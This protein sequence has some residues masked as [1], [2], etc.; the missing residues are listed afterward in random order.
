MLSFGTSLKFLRLSLGTLSVLMGVSVAVKQSNDASQGGAQE[1]ACH[2]LTSSARLDDAETHLRN[3]LSNDITVEDSE[4]SGRWAKDMHKQMSAA[5]CEVSLIGASEPFHLALQSLY[6]PLG[7]RRQL[8][9]KLGLGAKWADIASAPEE[10]NMKFDGGFGNGTK[11]IYRHAAETIYHVHISKSADSKYLEMGYF[12]YAIQH[13]HASP[14]P[15]YHDEKGK[16]WALTSMQQWRHMMVKQALLWQ[17]KALNQLEKAIEL[18]ESGST[19][20][21]IDEKLSVAV[22][23][24]GKTLHMIEDGFDL[25]HVRRSYSVGA[26][27]SQILDI[28]T[29]VSSEWQERSLGMVTEDDKRYLRNVPVTM[30][31]TMDDMHLGKHSTYDLFSVDRQMLN[32]SDTPMVPLAETDKEAEA[33]ALRN[34]QSIAVRQYVEMVFKVLTDVWGSK[35]GSTPPDPSREACEAEIAKFI[36]AET[37]GRHKLDTPEACFGRGGIVCSRK[38]DL[39]PTLTTSNIPD[40]CLPQACAGIESIETCVPGSERGKILSFMGSG[41]TAEVVTCPSD[42][43]S[44]FKTKASLQ[45]IQAQA[46][47]KLRDAMC[48]DFF[49]L[50][51]KSAGAGGTWP[52]VSINGIEWNAQIPEAN[53]EEAKKV[54]ELLQ[55]ATQEIERLRRAGEIPWDTKIPWKYPEPGEA[56]ICAEPDEADDCGENPTSRLAAPQCADLGVNLDD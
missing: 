54:K 48:D 55:A 39:T 7:W 44:T 22:F 45:D 33:E 56:D 8:C 3:R 34:I 51:D 41:C 23:F 21:A 30:A 36:G 47:T 19:Y 32:F 13:Q 38:T 9:T 35:Q 14:L 6:G 28:G 31:I 1:E 40:R 20:E 52:G 2:S 27:Y 4:S 24:F 25:A 50:V 18:V 12:R 26:N 15:P 46:S 10:Y 29:R 42:F 37:Y 5:M 49:P 43:R 17:C 16:H 53:S 11:E